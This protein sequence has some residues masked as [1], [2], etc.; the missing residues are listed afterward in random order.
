MRLNSDD[1]N[2]IKLDNVSDPIEVILPT[3]PFAGR[4]VD[5]VLLNFG[6]AKQV[7]ALQVV[8]ISTNRNR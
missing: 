7:N 3:I 1:H 4:A 8:T 2:V 6:S 5:G